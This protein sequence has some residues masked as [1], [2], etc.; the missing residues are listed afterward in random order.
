MPG[1]AIHKVF[2][3][4]LT[5]SLAGRSIKDIVI[6]K[7]TFCDIRSKL[8]LCYLCHRS[9]CS[10]HSNYIG[11]ASVG[12]GPNGEQR[13]QGGGIASCTDRKSCIEVQKANEGLTS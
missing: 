7:C 6:D 12:K 5:V 1:S 10:S 8:I 13:R 4:P 3:H 11:G 2:G 9:V